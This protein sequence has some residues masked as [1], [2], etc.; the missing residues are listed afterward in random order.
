MAAEKL[1]AKA[2]RILRRDLWV[3]L[4]PT[5]LIGTASKDTTAKGAA[6]V[7][8][9][10]GPTWAQQQKLTGSDASPNSQ[11]G[12]VVAPASCGPAASGAA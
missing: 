3:T 12:T 11:F 9:G 1:A 10:A 2:R 7:F 4:A 6:Y 5:V 8:V